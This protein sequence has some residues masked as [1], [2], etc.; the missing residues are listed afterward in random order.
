VT[1][2]NTLLDAVR[3]V[4]DAQDPEGLLALGAPADEYSPEVAA[5][6]EL[7]AAGPVTDAGVLAVWGHWFGPGSS[8]ARN[9]ERLHRLTSALA[10]LRS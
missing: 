8:V 6:A 3:R 2:P 10:G 9:P 7:V 5:L 1:D 4:V